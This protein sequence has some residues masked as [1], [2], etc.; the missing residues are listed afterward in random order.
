MPPNLTYPCAF[1]KTPFEVRRKNHRYCSARCRLTAFQG[2]RDGRI[3]DRDAKVRLLLKEAL[4]L[5]PRM[6][7]N[8]D[9]GE[10]I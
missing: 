5:L 4:R 8:D 7:G 6:E 10:G 1:C 9:E 3:Q 2:K